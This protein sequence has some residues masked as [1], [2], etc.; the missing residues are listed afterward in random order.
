MMAKFV[1]GVSEGTLITDVQPTAIAGPI[2]RAIIAAGK[3]QLPIR[4]GLELCTHGT[5]SAQTPIG[6][7]IEKFLVPG[8][9]QGIVFP[10][11]RTAS[12]ENQ[13]KKLAA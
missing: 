12:P 13:L 1:N 11:V 3:F 4:R 2:L 7:L 8:R 5:S 10:F 9:L 6:C